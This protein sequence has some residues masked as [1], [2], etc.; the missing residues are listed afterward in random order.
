MTPHTGTV[1][2]LI[3]GAGL[4]GLTMAKTY[5]EVN[6]SARLLVVDKARTVGGTWAH[7]R[8]YPGL[9]TNNIYG[10]YEL[11]GYPMRLKGCVRRPTHIPGQVVYDYFCAVVD[12]F[13]IK[14]HL[15]LCTTVTA[16]KLNDDSSWDVTL[17]YLMK[18]RQPSE[19]VR[20]A[21][22]VIATGLT[23][24]AHKPHIPGSDTFKGLI[25]HSKQLK[26][27][28]KALAKCPRVAVIGGNKSAW[29]VCYTAAL[30]GSQVHLIIRPSGGGPSYLWPKSFS[31]DPFG[32]F[33]VSLAWLS[34]TRLFILFDPS[35][36]TDTGPYMYLK[37]F[38][39]RTSLGQL[40]CRFFWWY[41]DCLI[42]RH[43]NYASHPELKKLEPWITPFW[44]GN[45]LSI[46]N[47]P[48]SW[49][50]LVRQGLISVHIADVASLSKERV[51]L[52]DGE[53]IGV[54]AV[55]LCTGWE[56]DIPVE[57]DEEGVTV[58]ER[59]EALKTIYERI[60]YL[61][62]FQRRTPNAPA[63]KGNQQ[64]SKRA[65]KPP[66]LYRNIIPCQQSFLQQKNLAFIGMSVSIHAVLVAQA[67]ALWITAFLAD[68]IPQLHSD[69]LLSK[70][71]SRAI[72]D[73]VYG[74]V[75]RPRETGGLAGQHADLVFDSLPYVDD[76][77]ADLGL[78]GTRKRG[79]WRELTEGYG[80]TDY[81]GLVI[82]WMRLQGLEVLN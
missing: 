60:P 36:F 21:R 57:L 44:M 28:A 12:R 35:P 82:E 22:L 27:K 50:D 34:L 7:E 76:L 9:R 31:L 20:A 6:P 69:N 65:S 16:T 64:A 39:H 70:V 49:F 17:Q 58:D 38:L 1:D 18:P 53:I 48:S 66:L 26:Q 19:T 30:H 47:Y 37:R 73:R 11:S 14:P 52:A 75:R 10:T 15:L 78:S 32:L 77:L 68:R 5:L 72:L 51:H 62:N 29:D 8:L 45:S 4:H 79:W 42:R 40:L 59:N 63:Y 55:V 54:D 67:Q 2:L 33:T 56:T 74:E 80:V 24:K 61:N 3:I 71:R 46:N 41:L 81:Y 13:R 23:S 25:L 43:N